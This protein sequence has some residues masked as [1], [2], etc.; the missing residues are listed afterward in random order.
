MKALNPVVF[1][2]DIALVELSNNRRLKSFDSLRNTL[3]DFQASYRSY[4]MAA[5]DPRLALMPQPLSEE[6]KAAVIGHFENPPAVIRGAIREIRDRLSPDVCPMCGS[7]GVGSVDHV[8][9]KDVY[10]E[11]SLH[12]K[13]L[14]PACYCNSKRRSV[15]W[16]GSDARVLHPY[17]DVILRTRLARATFT[18]PFENPIIGLEVCCGDIPMRGCVDYHVENVVLK[19]NV[20]NYMRNQWVLMMRRPD[21]VP[22]FSRATLDERAFCD[23]VR[24]ALQ[25]TDVEFGT[26]N[27]WKS[28]YLAGL[29]ADQGACRFALAQITRVKAGAMP[30]HF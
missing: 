23:A 4:V 14:V 1:D 10:A 7:L 9:P 25:R 12:T 27:N 6:L 21:T 16:N 8:F 2:D 11:L 28:M 29:L 20:L 17:F 13:N 3:D 19:T 18:P 30:D 15:F 5:G 22:E 24:E 26:P